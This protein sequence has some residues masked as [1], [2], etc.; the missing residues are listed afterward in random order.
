MHRTNKPCRN[1]GSQPDTWSC[2]TARR[3]EIILG[4]SQ[5]WVFCLLVCLASR[6]L[7]HIPAAG[8]F[9]H[10]CKSGMAT[11]SAAR[12]S[13][14][15]RAVGSQLQPAQRS[16]RASWA[17]AAPR[18]PAAAQQ[19]H[20]TSR[21]VLAA[22]EVETAGDS[23]LGIGGFMVACVPRSGSS[24]RRGWSTHCRSASGCCR[25]CARRDK[26]GHQGGPHS[27][28]REAPRR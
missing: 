21:V 19:R 16:L 11:M 27:E 2:S 13:R 9:T 5:P 3:T 1:V 26:D 18:Q 8:R 14:S 17:T 24:W 10:I 22:A 12:A 15:L 7:S 6:S 25:K 20:A 23:R 28:L 4:N